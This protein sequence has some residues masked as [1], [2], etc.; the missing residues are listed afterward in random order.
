MRPSL[1]SY[2]VDWTY[3][4]RVLKVLELLCRCLVPGVICDPGAPP[5]VKWPEREVNRLYLWSAKFKNEGSYSPLPHVPCF[6]AAFFHVGKMVA[7]RSCIWVL[8]LTEVVCPLAAVFCFISS[9]SVLWW[10]CLN[11]V[12]RSVVCNRL[13]NRLVLQ[14]RCLLLIG[15]HT[16]RHFSNSQ[17]REHLKVPLFANKVRTLIISPMLAEGGLSDL[18]ALLITKGERIITW[19]LDDSDGVTL[20]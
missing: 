5:G 12:R 4:F 19:T 15:A 10:I 8:F 20:S 13:Q 7:L 2:V 17:I 9:L 18:P 11:P 16:S 1:C 3:G 14:T 6:W